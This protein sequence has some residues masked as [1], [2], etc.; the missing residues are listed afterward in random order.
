MEKFKQ[1]MWLAIVADNVVHSSV[2]IG[3]IS[4][5]VMVFLKE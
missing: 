2:G 3:K 1:T 4:I 5:I